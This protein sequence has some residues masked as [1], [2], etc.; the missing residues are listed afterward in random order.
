MMFHNKPKKN[1]VTAVLLFALVSLVALSFGHAIK[2]ASAHISK[3]F[4]NITVELGWNNEPALTGQMNAAQLTVFTGT[5]DKPQYV[6]NAAAN[7]DTTLVYGTTTK[8]IEFQP[9]PTTDGQYLAPILPTKEGTYTVVFKGTI[10]GQNIDTQINLD[11]VASSDTISFPPSTSGN[12]GGNG[13]P[14]ITG[15]LGSIINQ[16]TNEITSAKSSADSAAQNAA[17][18]Q[19]IVQDAKSSADRAYLIGMTGIGVG[20]AGIAIAVVAISKRQSV[21]ERER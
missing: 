20:I 17:D 8:K 13:N 9:S 3:K 1:V 19:K 14:D 10:Q 7:L 5:A 4:G 12:T 15:Q 16:L 18:A 21:L 11:D 6:I 2:P